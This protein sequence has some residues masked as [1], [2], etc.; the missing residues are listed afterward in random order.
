VPCPTMPEQPVLTKADSIASESW[1]FASFDC[2]PVRRPFPERRREAPY[3]V[4]CRIYCN[5]PHRDPA[6]HVQASCNRLS[7]LL[8]PTSPS[9]TS[10]IAHQYQLYAIFI[11]LLSV[12]HV[13]H[14]TVYNTRTKLISSTCQGPS[15]LQPALQSPC[16]KS[17]NWQL[18]RV[19]ASLL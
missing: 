6:S 9:P 8:L 13:I 2:S 15:S 5:S 17:I 3:I 10:S 18:A 1:L 7:V 16:C 19:Y 14:N 12:I 4:T 11:Q